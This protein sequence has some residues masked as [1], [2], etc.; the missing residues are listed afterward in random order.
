MFLFAYMMGNINNLIEKLDNDHQEF[1]EEESELLDQWIMKID[2]ANP[3]RRLKPE[4]IKD[5][6]DFFRTYWQKDHTMVQE[7]FPF[8]NQLPLKVRSQ[9]A[10]T[11]YKRRGL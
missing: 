5:I 6:K 11:T 2:R 3:K 9:V 1:I 4:M 7:E 8:L 10:L